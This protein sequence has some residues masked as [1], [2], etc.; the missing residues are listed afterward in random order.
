MGAGMRPRWR[1]ARTWLW[2]LA[3]LTTLALLLAGLTGLLLRQPLSALQ[4][5]P[6]ALGHG[7][8]LRVEALHGGWFSTAAELSLTQPAAAPL[9]LRLRLQHGPWPLDRLRQGDLRPAALSARLQALATV[10]P[11]RLQGDLRLGYLASLQAN[12]QLSG[13]LLPLGGWSLQPDDLQLALQAS[14]FGA[15]LQLTAAALRA[16]SRP[17]AAL[18]VQAQQWR[19]Q[20]DIDSPLHHPQA[21]LQL[22]AAQLQLAQGSHPLLAVQGLSQ[23]AAL[24]QPGELADLRLQAQAAQLS[25]WG[26]PIG[27]L[28]QHVVVEGFSPAGLGAALGGQ[29]AAWAEALPVASTAAG[30]VLAVSSGAGRSRLALH[31]AA[32]APGLQVEA[33]LSRPQFLAAVA[34]NPALASQGERISQQQAGQFYALVSQPLLQSGLF[35]AAETGL[36]ARL[37]LDAQG[38]RPVLAAGSPP[39]AAR[40]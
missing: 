28:A 2:L 39:P 5:Q 25:L 31:K 32:G 12:L 16:D 37:L 35:Q 40:P 13:L 33:L 27:P 36:Q 7:A 3:G 11:A 19:L 4:R 10:A 15:A 18:A 29:A 17:V 38:L 20:A 14:P 26:Q 21:Q 22:S 1:R 6:L 34:G 23:Q 24:A 30:E 8:E 9:H